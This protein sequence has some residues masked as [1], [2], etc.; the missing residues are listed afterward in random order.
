MLWLI[1]GILVLVGGA[2]ALFKRVMALRLSSIGFVLVWLVF[3]VF[4][5]TYAEE[6]DDPWELYVTSIATASASA[7]AGALAAIKVVLNRVSSLESK[8]NTFETNINR[9]LDDHI[10][11]TDRLLEQFEKRIIDRVGGTG[12]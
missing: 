1:V 5:I 3:V 11:A 6:H 10:A 8:F 7:I 9:R 2:I 4:I 12:R